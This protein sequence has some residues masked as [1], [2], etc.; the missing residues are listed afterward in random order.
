V[1]RFF[2][3]AAAIEEKIAGVAA[4]LADYRLAL[5]DL[6]P[7]PSVSK[8]VAGVGVAAQTRATC[9][10]CQAPLEQRTGRYGEFTAC[11]RY[12]RC[13]YTQV[14]TTGIACPACATGKIVERRASGA[15]GASRIFYGCQR[16]PA[17][18]FRSSYRPVG[19][20]C[21]QCSSPFLEERRLGGKRWAKCPQRAC[22][23][24]REIA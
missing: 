24:K 2:C 9:P 15:P 16:Y 20:K 8:S 11:S 21:P 1:Q 17:C 14:K 10:D 13:R 12:P 6:G 5:M 19:E 3:P 18:E 4:G 7:P 22:G 23:W